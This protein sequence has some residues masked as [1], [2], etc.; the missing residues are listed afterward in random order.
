MK[1]PEE[2]LDEIISANN[3]NAAINARNK[4]DEI[5]INFNN[6]ANI[7]RIKTELGNLKM[8]VNNIVNSIKANNVKLNALKQMIKTF[9]KIPSN[10][11]NVD[12][13]SLIEKFSKMLLGVDNKVNNINQKFDQFIKNDN[14]KNSYNTTSFYSDTA[15]SPI[16]TPSL[17]TFPYRQITKKYFNGT[18]VGEF[19]NGLREG[20]GVIY[21]DNGDRYEGEYKNDL[22][23]GKG[24]YYFSDGAKYEGD[25]K[26]DKP[27]GKGV[28]YYIDG[29][30]YEGDF[31]NGKQE[32]K[33]KFYFNNGDR[34]EG[35]YKNDVKEGK[36]TYYYK[37]GVKEIGEYK[38]DKPSG[39]FCR[40]ELDGKFKKIK[41]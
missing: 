41:Y 27:N 23:E 31:V 20:K 34:F 17:D 3:P 1:N 7:D 33:G 11:K 16:T 2:L 26:N 19:K 15:I 28:Y 25:F 35:E 5:L 18:Y 4:V 9:N 39:V 30:K 6:K 37:N 32:G 38:K 29:A 36:G 22:K 24:I 12:V 21:G 10:E 8:M 40:I 14:R 13:S